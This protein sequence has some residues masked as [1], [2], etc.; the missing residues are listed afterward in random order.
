MKPYYEQAGITIYHGDCRDFAIESEAVISDPPYGM[1]CKTNSNRF[2]GGHNSHRRGGRMSPPIVGDDAPF[3]PAPWLNYKN[4]I[5]WGFNHFASRL[6]V[7]RTLVWIKRLDGAF[8][9]FLSDAELAWMKGGHGVYCHR[10]LSMMSV[11]GHRVHPAE[12]PVQL[13]KWCL[14]QIGEPW[15]IGRVLD[16]Y[17]GSG[18]TLIA[19]K[20]LGLRAVGIEIEE[21]YCEIA[22]KRLSQDVLFG[23]RGV[24]GRN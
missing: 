1:R 16:P 21:R 12:K 22:A 11:Q 23:G 17:C 10:D 15:T 9:S 14:L 4:V 3:D 2:T 19:A 24:N 20:D 8:G 5:L 6:P 18:S 13:M 7:G